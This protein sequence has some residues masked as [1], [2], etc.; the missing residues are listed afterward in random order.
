ME[1]FAGF[2]QFCESTIFMPTV[3]KVD[4]TEFLKCFSILHRFS[5]SC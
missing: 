3:A 2:R 5:G 4:L 1:Q